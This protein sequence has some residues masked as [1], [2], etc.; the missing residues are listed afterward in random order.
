MNKNA[1]KANV[2]FFFFMY[3]CTGNIFKVWNLKKTIKKKTLF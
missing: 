2:V 1:I 3:K